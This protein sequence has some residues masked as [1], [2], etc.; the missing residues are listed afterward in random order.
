[1]TAATKEQRALNAELQ[2]LRTERREWLTNRRG[3]FAHWGVP[4]CAGGS[5][6]EG[7]GCVG[8]HAAAYCAGKAAEMKAR[9]KALLNPPPAALD[10]ELFSRID[11]QWVTR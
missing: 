7:L 2:Q 8:C 4:F 3:P 11:G 1:M 6:C 5:N 10:G 9:I